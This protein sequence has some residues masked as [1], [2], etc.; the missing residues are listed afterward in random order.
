[1]D[2]TDD[3]PL[4]VWP[5]AERNKQPILEALQSIIPQGHGSILEI[6]AATGQH[7]LH[8]A[9]H[10]P[11]YDY[12]VSDYDQ[13]HLKTL[14][15]RVAASRIGNLM[16]PLLLDTTAALWPLA[17]IDVIY[18]ANMMHIAP[19]A[20]TVGLFRGAG[21][22]LRAG[23]YLLTYGPYKVDGQHTSESNESFDASL[24]QRDPLWGVRDLTDLKLLADE[25]GLSLM[26]QRF[27]PANNL[28]LVWQK[29]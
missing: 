12:Y 22:T 11:G 8:F 25:H 26:Q 5:A 18:N 10:F 4:P 14:K 28:L 2:Q 20:A 7:A 16:G 24:K 21:R 17:Q 27:M 13:E 19:F 9:P 23:G 3:S 15:R 6:S 29:D 1:M